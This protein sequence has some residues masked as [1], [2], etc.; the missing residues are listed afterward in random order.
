M[1]LLNASLGAC[2]EFRLCERA[3]VFA[4]KLGAAFF[5]RWV[6]WAATVTV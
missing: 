6:L 1:G 3:R 2:G 5:I 4:R